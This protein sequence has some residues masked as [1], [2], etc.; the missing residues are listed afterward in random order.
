MPLTLSKR[1]LEIAPSMTLAIDARAKDLK[2]QGVDV[3]GFGA[4]EPDFDTPEYIR[5]AAKH[6][7][8]AGM[9]RY[10]PVSG[11]LHLREEICTKLQCD[12]NLTYTPAQVIVTTGAKQAL[13]NA[14]SAI[15]NP[16]SSVGPTCVITPS[17][18]ATA[19]SSI[20]PK[21]DIS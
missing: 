11:T 20:T 16:P 17:D 8:D 21:S 4:G 5:D 18:I 19:P 10:T 3:V 13:F 2:A 14:L 15:V 9:T 12:N 6:A 7:L 1:C